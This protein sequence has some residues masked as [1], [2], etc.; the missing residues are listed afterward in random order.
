MTGKL[1]SAYHGLVSPEARYWVY[2]LRNPQEFRRLREVVHPSPKGDFSLRSF[3][4]L[5]CIFVHVTKAAGTAVAKTLFGE[6][7]YHY[8]AWQYRVIYGRRT[9]RRYF[10]FAFVRNPW[11]RLHS[12]YSFLASGGWNES[13]ARWYEENLGHLSDFNSFVMDWLAPDRL[14]AHVHFWPQRDFLCDHRGRLLV[15]FLGHFETLH[16]D[17]DHVARELGLTRS[18]A[19]ENASGKRDYRGVYTLEAREKVAR[20]YAF[21][22]RQFGYDFDGV[23]EGAAEGNDGT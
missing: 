20:L 13:D 23:R 19:R 18:L 10:K 2:K 6:L 3:D 22:I 5:H 4:R 15:D 9:F 8:T 1:R 14:H 21:D 12:A 16:A 17:F 11:D 7:P